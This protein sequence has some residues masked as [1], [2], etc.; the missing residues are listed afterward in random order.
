MIWIAAAILT[1]FFGVQVFSLVS[2]LQHT[3]KKLEKRKDWEMHRKAEERK[4]MKAERERERH[5]EIL[6]EKRRNEKYAQNM[7]TNAK[8]DPL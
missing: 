3:D 5:E 7:M 4:R 6:R 8:L 1:I 2:V